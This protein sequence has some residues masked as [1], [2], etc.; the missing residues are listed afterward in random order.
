MSSPNIPPPPPPPQ[1]IKQPDQA[2]MNTNAR[3]N[4]A[5]SMMGGSLLTGP[6]GVAQGALTTGRTSLLGQ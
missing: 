2:T 6:S 1:E 3:R 5:G 4:R